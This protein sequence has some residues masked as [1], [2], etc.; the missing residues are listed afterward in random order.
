MHH[1]RNV[2][3]LHSSNSHDRS[4]HHVVTVPPFLPEDDT[5]PFPLHKIHVRPMLT[6]DETSQLLNLAKSYASNNKSWDK[7]STRH[8]SYNTV[9][10]AIEDSIEVSEYLEDISFEN[11]IFGA[12][13]EVYDIDVEDMSF[14]DM[15][16]ASYEA[17]AATQLTGGRLRRKTMDRLEYHRDGSLLSFSLLLSSPDDFE[18]G[19]TI[20]EALRDVPVPDDHSILKAEG[21]IRPPQAGYATLH[22]G[23]L[24]HGGNVV[25]RGQR[26]IIVGFVDIDVRNVKDDALFNA[27]KEWG[28]NDVRQFWNKRRLDILENQ[29]EIGIVGKDEIYPRWQLL[30]DELLPK[31]GR[32][33]F[34]PGVVLPPSIIDKIKNR[35]HNDVIRMRRLKTEDEF[36]RHTLL[37][38]E[39]RGDKVEE[40]ELKEVEYDE[41]GNMILPGGWQSNEMKEG[42]NFLALRNDKM[43]KG[44]LGE[45]EYTDNGMPTGIEVADT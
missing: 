24:L 11:R 29:Q 28:R 10:F 12:M 25:T 23:K 30:N 34:G 18:G 31:K 4:D 1:R 8:V 14:L 5:Y 3:T 32:S 17:K 41:Y 37:P 20:F 44:E 42:E 40:G 16:C 9:D 21:V 33:C 38:R 35:A 45:F 19:G 39:L 43:K 36:L 13:S 2:F 6:E 22:S 26:I 7:D 27:A 15:F